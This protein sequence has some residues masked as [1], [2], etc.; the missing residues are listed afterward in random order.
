MLYSIVELPSCHPIPTFKVTN[1]EAD[2]MLLEGSVKELV[3]KR[4]ESVVDQLV[5]DI[6]G[7]LPF[8][9]MEE[10]KPLRYV[11]IYLLQTC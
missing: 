5:T 3:V 1:A 9:K 2:I 7:L 4:L 6:S 8:V 10:L 11:S